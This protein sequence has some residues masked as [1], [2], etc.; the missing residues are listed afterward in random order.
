MSVILHDRTT[1]TT[2]GRARQAGPVPRTR[3]G[4]RRHNHNP[5]DC[6]QLELTSVL[7]AELIGA[8]RQ[9]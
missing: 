9:E 3:R 5:S 8:T 1:A 4:I 6:D 7:P 2:G